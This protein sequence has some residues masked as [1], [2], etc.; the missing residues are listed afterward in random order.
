MSALQRA[1]Q[2][3][4][5][6]RPH[7]ARRPRCLIVFGP[8]ERTD[9]LPAAPWRAGVDV[10]CID[11]KVGVTRAHVCAA[12]QARLRGGESSAAFTGTPCESMAHR[13]QLRSRKRPLGLE[14][15]P[16]EWRLYLAK[17]NAFAAWTAHLIAICEEARVAWA[18]E[19][20]DVRD[21]EL[22]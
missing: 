17:H 10:V 12:I 14:E 22:E 20:Y 3:L 2:R 11:T 7:D 15:V 5:P 18:V 4:G 8:D 21:V 9:G 13:P 1:R 19:E 16:P 6:R